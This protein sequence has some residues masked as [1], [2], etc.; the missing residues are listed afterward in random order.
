MLRGAPPYPRKLRERQNSETG[1]R[2]PRSSA[3][4]VSP[5]HPSCVLGERLDMTWTARAAAR[6][7]SPRERQCGSVHGFGILLIFPILQFVSMSCARALV[8]SCASTSAIAE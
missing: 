8:R 7:P 6:K 1:G 4:R 2:G 5:G 3:A